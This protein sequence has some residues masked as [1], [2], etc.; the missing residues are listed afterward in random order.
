ME[1]KKV[2]TKNNSI[3]QYRYNMI[4]FAKKHGIRAAAREFRTD[5]KTVKKWVKEY[6]KNYDMNSLKNKSRLGQYHPNK[7]SDDEEKKIIDL[8]GNSKIGAYFI[9]DKLMLNCSLKTIHK[10]LKQHGKVGK[11]KKKSQKKRDMSEIRKNTPVMRKLQ[12]DVKYLCDIPNLYADIWAI[13]IPKYQITVRDY[14]CGWTMIGFSYHKD[15]TSIGIFVAYVIYCLIKAGIDISNIYFQSDNG[16]EF[17]NINK[18]HGLSLY[19]EILNL[20]GI[21]YWFI[22][23]AR[24]TFNSDVES[25]HNTIE[26]ELYDTDKMG[27]EDTLLMK[28]WSYM[29]WYNCYR[30]NRNKEHKAPLTI[31]KE[32]Y[33]QVGEK[34]KNIKLNKLM[35]FPPIIVDRYIKDIEVIKKVGE[36]RWLAPIISFYFS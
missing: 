21:K 11:P 5:R 14:K 7:L 4:L 30:K 9:K 29:I 13:N 27:D 35:S 36:L 23:P 1:N 3:E 18:K 31:L 32:Y 17:R 24:P 16:S 20:Y 8:R 22:P 19:E 26:R 33:L 34:E 15:S 2:F 28:A 10:K 12:I 25:F 6:Q